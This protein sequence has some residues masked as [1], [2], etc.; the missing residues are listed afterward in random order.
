MIKYSNYHNMIVTSVAKNASSSDGYLYDSLCTSAEGKE[1]NFASLTFGYEFI[2]AYMWLKMKDTSNS[3]DMRSLFE[4][5]TE[6]SL[7]TLSAMLKKRFQQDVLVNRDIDH[8]YILGGNI[9]VPPDVKVTSRH[10]VRAYNIYI[11][12]K[13]E[14]LTTFLNNICRRSGGQVG[15]INSIVYTS[16]ADYKRNHQRSNLAALIDL[17]DF[18]IPSI[19]VLLKALGYNYFPCNPYL[20]ADNNY[21]K[22]QCIIGGLATDFTDKNGEV[23]LYYTDPSAKEPFSRYKFIP[24]DLLVTM[25][26]DNSAFQPM[27]YIV[28]QDKG[29]LTN[30]II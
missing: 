9:I 5:K 4:I 23:R 27:E 28:A 6:R 2:V 25:L 3:A 24:Y 21:G 7:G 26:M 8:P 19:I 12:N 17:I 16:A 1:C 18:P 10:L 11:N 22:C 14:P 15:S 13:K 30:D 20:D 29:I